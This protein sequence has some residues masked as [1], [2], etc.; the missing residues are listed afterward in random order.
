MQRQKG[1]GRYEG[2][3]EKKYQVETKNIGKMYSLEYTDISNVFFASHHVGHCYS[4][5]YD[6]GHSCSDVI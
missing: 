2:I 5:T 1:K 3:G 6:L 4:V